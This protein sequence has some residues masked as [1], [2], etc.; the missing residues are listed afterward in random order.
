MAWWPRAEAAAVEAIEMKWNYAHLS[1]S[2]T[3]H[4]LSQWMR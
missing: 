4:F 2:L 1:A 3:L